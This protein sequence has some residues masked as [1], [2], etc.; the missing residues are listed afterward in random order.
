MTVIDVRRM[1]PK[2]LHQFKI[3]KLPKINNHNLQLVAVM[4]ELVAG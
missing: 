1:S 4:K 3:K 2:I